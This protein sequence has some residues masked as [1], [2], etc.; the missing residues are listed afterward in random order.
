MN[1]LFHILISRILNLTLTYSPISLFRWQLYA[2]QGMRNKWYSFLGSDMMEES[3][4]DQDA[5][6]VNTPQLVNIL[7]LSIG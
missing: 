5:L 7:Q 4:E 6:K 1:Y 2:A 3:D